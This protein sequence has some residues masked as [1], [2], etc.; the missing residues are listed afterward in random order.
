[1]AV[2]ETK[3][4]SRIP[5]AKV[6]DLLHEVLPAHVDDETIRRHVQATAER[7][8]EELGEERQLNLFEASQSSRRSWPR[9]MARLR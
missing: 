8:E 6:A 2:L 4:A 5:F 9:P 7:M 3:W 1:M